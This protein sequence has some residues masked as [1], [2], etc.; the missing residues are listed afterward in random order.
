MKKTRKALLAV[1]ACSVALAGAVGLAACGG[2]DDGDNGTSHDHSW[3]GWTVATQPTDEATGKATRTCSGEGTCDAKA[4]DKEYTLPALTSDDYTKGEDSATCAAAGTV[5]YTYNKNDVNVS[6][7]VATAKK[8]HTEE[9]VKGKAAT[10]SEDGLTDGKKCT[11]CGETTVEQK[12]IDAHHTEIT[13]TQKYPTCTEDGLTEGK[14]CTIC[15]EVTVEQ[16]KVDALGHVES[17]LPEVE[18]T[19][20]EDGLTAGKKCA[21]CQEVL[22]PQTEVKAEGHKL[23]TTATPI[24]VPKEGECATGGTVSQ[25]CTVCNKSI[26]YECDN[27]VNAT[28]A[29][30]PSA[31]VALSEGINYV[32]QTPSNT[33]RP[34]Y[35]KYTFTE[36][37]TYTFY[38]K[39]LNSSS[40][41]LG[42]VTTSGVAGTGP[43]K[44][45]G[46]LQSAYITEDFV[47]EGY[48]ASSLTYYVT[49]EEGNQVSKTANKDDYVVLT[50]NSLKSPTGSY[51]ST[52]ALANKFIPVKLTI[53][54]TEDMVTASKY[55]AFR[56]FP[57][58]TDTGCFLIGINKEPTVTAELCTVGEGKFTIKDSEIEF[59]PVTEQGTY[60]FTAASGKFELYVND[61]LYSDG[62]KSF[63]GYVGF[64]DRYLTVNLQ[65]GDAVKIVKVAGRASDNIVTIHEGT[66]EEPALPE[67]TELEL[68]EGTVSLS[69]TYLTTSKYEDGIEK[70]Y[71]FTAAESG[72]FEMSVGEDVKVS[73]VIRVDKTHYTTVLDVDLMNK[74]SGVFYAEAGET[75]I[76]AF[77]GNN[78]EEFTVNIASCA[79]PVNYLNVNEKLKNIAFSGIETFVKL[80]VGDSVA[81]GEYQLTFIASQSLHRSYIY[82]SVNEEIEVDDVYDS[83]AVGGYVNADIATGAN[84]TVGAGTRSDP[85]D[86]L[87]VKESKDF[88]RTV[89]L[90]AGDVIYMATASLIPGCVD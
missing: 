55:I 81:E 61:N 84:N 29:A 20:T 40:F 14:K 77:T 37:G 64:C 48:A 43:I 34:P 58:S 11:V 12:K 32:S 7:D 63:F 75:I 49:D 41:Y 38:W 5:T 42:P 35:F 8:A 28:D 83:N 44:T 22:V 30:S 62:V 54:V 13:L 27:V 33:S 74:R 45:N 56:N 39:G 71:S 50:K 4:T 79:E 87:A 76:I 86:D 66:L 10:C 53:E 51:Q 73:A 80:T 85:D 3:G 23:S 68:G 18:A 19:C 60:T 88:T 52:F 16:V 90:K 21:V 70:F 1:L 24:Y 36:E 26:V 17:T 69:E 78:T 6:F 67:Y 65:E 2:G 25:R 72:Y 9:V 15:G 46:D 47:I 82:F 89:T 57:N 31:A 59:V